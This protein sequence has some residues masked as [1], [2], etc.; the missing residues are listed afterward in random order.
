MLTTKKMLGLSA[1]FPF[2]VGNGGHTMVPVAKEVFPHKLLSS[3]LIIGV[4]RANW[5]TAARQ[6]GIHYNARHHQGN[7]KSHLV[8][9]LSVSIILRL[10]LIFL[11]L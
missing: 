4:V 11:K 6:S 7:Q 8:S 1:S 9:G 10:M 5:H 2:A 3:E